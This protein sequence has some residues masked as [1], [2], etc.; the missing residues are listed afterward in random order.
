[1]LQ[2]AATMSVS[3]IIIN[4]ITLFRFFF[5]HIYTSFFLP[6]YLLPGVEMTE[7]AETR[8]FIS[9]DAFSQ[10]PFIRPPPAMDKEKEKSESEDYYSSGIRIFGQQ[11]DS[12][13]G[14]IEK[15]A[16]AYSGGGGGARTRAASEENSRKFECHYCRRNFPTSQALGGHQNAHKRER[17]NA[18][19]AHL[20]TALAAA[21]HNQYHHK[22]ITEAHLKSFA[23]NYHRSVGPVGPILSS[24]PYSRFSI[25]HAFDFHSTPYYSPW[26]GGDMSGASTFGSRNY[27]V[28]PRLYGGS[29]STLSPLQPMN[30]NPTGLWRSPIPTQGSRE[31]QIPLHRNRSMSAL[32]LFGAG[33][34]TTALTD[35]PAPSTLSSLPPPQIHP[36]AYDPKTSAVKD[37]HFSLD[38]HL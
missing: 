19:R 10:L 21:S 31:I 34:G 26:R 29:G 37:H 23:N 28:L 9:V 35:S 14:T 24:P 1:M 7:R 13:E 22:V 25:D 27:T 36:F 4:Q 32:P 6:I 30:G 5:S 16:S 17:Q 15:T 38:L 8:D 3:S 12:K 2:L 11:I 33:A 18:K 20:Q